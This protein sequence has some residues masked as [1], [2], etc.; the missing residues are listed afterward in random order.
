MPYLQRDAHGRIES[1]HRHA[2]TQATEFAA[3]DDPRVLAFIGLPPA[4][5]EPGKAAD[6][7]QEA[8]ADSLVRMDASFVRVIEDL[9]DLLMV[10]NV[11]TLTDLPIQAQ[12]KLLA[13]KSF[14]DKAGASSLRLFGDV[15]SDG[16]L[17]GPD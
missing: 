13:R 10:K 1:L 15:G 16:P 8:E 6:G 2:S 9:I 11:I 3:D 5:V 4:A 12:N 7:D 17:L 14:R